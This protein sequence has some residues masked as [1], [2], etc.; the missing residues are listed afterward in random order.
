MIK[1]AIHRL[2]RVLHRSISTPSQLKKLSSRHPSVANAIRE[3]LRHQ[4]TSDEHQWVDRIENL[5]KTLNAN[6]EVI[7][8]RD[9][10]AGNPGDL[11]TTEDRIVGVKA[12]STV[13][14]VARIA[15]KHRAFGLLLFKLVRSVRAVHC[16]EMGTCLGISGAYLAAALELN[17]DGDLITLE[18]AESLARIAKDN[19]SNL[20]LTQRVSIM[21]GRF[22][23]TLNGAISK[24]VQI[25][26]ID[27]N[28][29]YDATMKYWDRIS[30]VM[31]RGS[32]VIFD[33]IS[34]YTGMEKAWR[35]LQSDSRF[36]STIDMFSVGIGI[37]GRD[38]VSP[39]AFKISIG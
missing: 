34:G 13:A 36:I 3:V 17:G 18:G 15:S 6:H 7:E 8:Y 23:D 37:V 26:F 22:D 39:E 32:V 20:G 12:K 33:D 1:G 35:E 30:T 9:F 16:I 28:H 2:K 38:T 5:R 24:P 4:L 10:G 27:G 14:K 11:R 19:F 25:A 31:P 29:E 21:I